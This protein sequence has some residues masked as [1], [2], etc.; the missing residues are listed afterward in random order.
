MKKVIVVALAGLLLLSG[1]G[2]AEVSVN[3][4]SAES[5]VESVV[6]QVSVESSNQTAVVSESQNTHEIVGDDIFEGDRYVSPEIPEDTYSLIPERAAPVKDDAYWEALLND[7]EEWTGDDTLEEI[8]ISLAGT[9]EII[10]LREYNFDKI[11]KDKIGCYD[12][13]IFVALSFSTFEE[14]EGELDLTC[15]HKFY[16][17]EIIDKYVYYL[18]NQKI[19]FMKV[20]GYSPSQA[21]VW[22]NEFGYGGGGRGPE[23]DQIEDTGDGN[24]TVLMTFI[25]EEDNHLLWKSEYKFTVEGKRIIVNSIEILEIYDQDWF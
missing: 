10:G 12:E 17:E 2:Q 14:W 23:I 16:K 15:S 19:D 5:S 22:A 6:S 18:F 25:D 20:T 24:Y 8:F 13:M 21:G 1:C 9:L 7:V 11:E 4:S 3:S